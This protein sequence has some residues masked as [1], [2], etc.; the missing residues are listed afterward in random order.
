MN[1][2]YGKKFGSFVHVLIGVVIFLVVV[3]TAYTF[4]NI[5]MMKQ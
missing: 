4:G 5:Y 3:L 1:Y 2:D